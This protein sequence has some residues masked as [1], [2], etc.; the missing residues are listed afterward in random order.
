MRKSAKSFLTIIIVL[1]IATTCTKEIPE[2]Q[3]KYSGLRGAYLG[4]AEPDT[5]AQI[6]ASGIVSTGLNERDAAFSPDGNE[7]YFS[8][9]QSSKGTIVS[10]KQV[11]GKWTNPKV[12]SFS[13]IY[14][15]LEPFITNDGQK[16]FFASNR[17]TE[18]TEPIDYNIWVAERANDNGW[19]QPTILDSAINSKADEFYPTLTENGD[20]YFTSSNKKAL[21]SE[22][23]F[24]SKFVTGKYQEYENLGDSVNSPRDEFNSFIANDGSYLIY[25]TTGFGNGFGGG[26][27]WVSFKKDDG[28]WSRPKNLG[29][30]INSNKLDYCPS[31]T[32]DGKFMFFT[33]TKVGEREYDKKTSYEQLVKDY[34]NPNNGAGDI[35]WVSAE[36]IQKLKSKMKN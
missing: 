27:L 10:M 23:I 12:V 8:I 13:G 33:S 29:D 34:N 16:L 25:G 7:F 9:W 3:R 19:S 24:V 11:N 30:K 1:F 36:V 31:I 28:S 6:F 15:D 32:K 26:D 14:N 22:D 21:G 35:Y 4:Q 20:L 5:S 17:P 2:N 18:G